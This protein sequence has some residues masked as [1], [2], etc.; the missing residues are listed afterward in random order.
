M[1]QNTCTYECIYTGAIADSN[2]ER[3][4]L[5]IGDRIIMVNGKKIKCPEDWDN[6]MKNR[7]NFQRLTV[8]RDGKWINFTIKVE[9]IDSNGKLM[10]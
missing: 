7:G 1:K 10:N 2:A 8:I 6:A 9:K 4:G 5:L 3:S